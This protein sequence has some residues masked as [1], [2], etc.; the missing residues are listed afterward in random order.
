MKFLVLIL[1]ILLSFATSERL[2]LRATEE[3]HKLYLLSILSYPDPEPSLNPSIADGPD[4]FP[5]AQLAVDHV[6]NRSDVLRDYSLEL[7]E[8]DGG[9]N[10]TSK[11]LIRLVSQLFHNDKQIVGIIGPSCSD[12]AKEVGAVA[13]RSEIALISIHHGS[14]A[15]LA[16]R[17]TYPY[18]IGIA[19]SAEDLTK[20]LI[21][22]IKKAKWSRVAA[23]YNK[24]ML[25]DYSTFQLFEKET[26]GTGIKIVFSEFSSDTF[27]PHQELKNSYARVILGFVRPELAAKLLCVAFH[28]DLIY[29][30]YQWFLS[31]GFTDGAVSFY[32]T[33]ED[34]MYF[35]SAREM[36]DAREGLILIGGIPVGYF[37]ASSTVSGLAREEIMEEYFERWQTYNG[38]INPSNFSFPALLEY[39]AV[40]S[41]ALALNGSLDILQEK[42]MSLSNYTYGQNAITQVIMD[43]FY[44]LEFQ[45]ASGNISFNN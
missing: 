17:T 32:Y 36:Q 24:E 11:A 12:S 40:W 18:S 28:N 35:C 20:A 27:I 22:L 29:P 15:V 23:L 39:D 3:Q 14:S 42:N 21:E 4:L 6:N 26:K 37:D 13:G 9:C 16:N 31:N 41:M 8:A 19:V 1:G 33:P 2:R 44:Q 7:I 43:Q 25:V 5:A 45:G 38:N 10:V 30:K 34:K